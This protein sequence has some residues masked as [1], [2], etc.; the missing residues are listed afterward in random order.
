MVFQP[1]KPQGSM[2]DFGGI[3]LFMLASLSPFSLTSIIAFGYKNNVFSPLFSSI[4]SHLSRSQ[5]Q[6]P[7]PAMQSQ[8]LRWEGG[9]RHQASCGL[10][11]CCQSSSSSCCPLLPPWQPFS[12]EHQQAG[13]DTWGKAA[14]CLLITLITSAKKI[15]TKQHPK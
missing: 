5:N 15:P 14:S 13:G 4:P 10:W 2:L 6:A 7:V 11:G 8:L 1:Q 12:R 9:G 3:R